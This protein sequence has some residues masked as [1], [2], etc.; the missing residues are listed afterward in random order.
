MG[1]GPWLLWQLTGTNEVFPF[2]GFSITE[3]TQHI[4]SIRRAFLVGTSSIQHQSACDNL[5]CR[6]PGAVQ[7]QL[8]FFVHKLHRV[9]PLGKS[10]NGKKW[11]EK[12]N[13]RAGG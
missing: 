11:R 2:V 8:I 3:F 10:K 6:P 1:S 13:L 7:A 4:V 9:L 12:K 5:D